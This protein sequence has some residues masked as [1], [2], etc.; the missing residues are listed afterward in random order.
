MKPILETTISRYRAFARLK[1]ELE[2][3]RSQLEERRVVD[4]A[5]LILMKAKNI[6]EQTAYG[7]IRR[8]AMNE[9]KRLVEIAQSIITA[10]ELLR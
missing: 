4:R 10:A 5:K 7:L 6:D 9:K 1:D 3:A 2:E 8:T